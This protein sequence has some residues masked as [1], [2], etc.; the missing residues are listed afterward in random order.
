MK[1]TP[2]N[3][4]YLLLFPVLAVGL[5]LAWNLG[6]GHAGGEAR[7]EATREQVA[8]TFTPTLE[9]AIPEQ[10][11]VAS[12]RADLNE[13]RVVVED[14]PQVSLKIQKPSLHG[15][16]LK[17]DG[18]RAVGALVGLVSM[19][20]DWPHGQVYK[21]TNK[22][23]EFSI[24]KPEALRG[25]DLRLIARLKGYQPD[26]QILALDANL[27]KQPLILQL[28]VGSTISG[29]VL[30][31]GLP[32]ADARI[33]IDAA[34][35]TSGVFGVGREAW[36]AGGRLE[37]KCAWATTGNDGSF[38]ITGLGSYEHRLHIDPP[39]VNVPSAIVR[40]FAVRAP[41][42]RVYE[43]EAARLAI[44]VSDAQGIVSGAAI[45]VLSR[46]R[47][48]QLTSAADPVQI[49]VPP[50]E[51]IHITV[52]HGSSR[53][54]TIDVESPAIGGV[55]EVTIA[56]DHI[57]RPSLTVY[58]PGA[59]AAGIQLVRLRLQARVGFSNI[60]LDVRR[61][62][63]PDTFEVASIPLDPGE[64]SL[65][66]EPL[67]QAGSRAKYIAPRIADIELP[68]V[69]NVFVQL[70]FE[71]YGRC[72]VS[73]TSSHKDD[74]SSTYRILDADGRHVLGQ[75]VFY[76]AMVVDFGIN[77][78]AEED[79]IGG[80]DGIWLTSTSFSIPAGFGSKRGRP[81]Q[82]SEVMERCGVLPAGSYTLE[83]ESKGHALWTAPIT[84]EAGETT[85][86]K[87]GLVSEGGD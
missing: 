7:V 3:R 45:T 19:L 31:D 47:G 67:G 38:E 2:Q 69:G 9:L 35:G 60:G 1:T 36:W 21:L 70:E 14:S 80:G 55:Q 74:W 87:A 20:D 15:H 48:H 11:L 17:P 76:S 57:E 79:P 73:I 39:K 50:L 12:E 56:L 71:L 42:F 34:Y 4:R 64:Y 28:G 75:T 51:T 44:S 54:V 27:L 32:V 49:D 13:E 26:S 40:V 6:G 29:R 81:E 77:S 84:I 86:I 82:L 25:Q 61:G 43:L 33:S 65:I 68:A 66:L 46:G 41:D 10:P 22:R 78:E 8:E 58:L 83:V 62:A 59:T 63:L 23:G 37:E 72:K 53:D 16:V 52:R 5:W 24:T 18:T 85:R 30:R